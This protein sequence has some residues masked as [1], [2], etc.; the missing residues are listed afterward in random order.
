MRISERADAFARK[1]RPQEEPDTR[2]PAERLAEVARKWSP[3]HI[4]QTRKRVKEAKR[5]AD[6]STVSSTNGVIQ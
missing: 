3:G 1:I 6:A 4:R 5:S 2:T